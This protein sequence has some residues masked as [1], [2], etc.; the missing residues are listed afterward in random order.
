MTGAGAPAVG[1]RA[2]H[3]RPAVTL[4]PTVDPG[5][6]QLPTGASGSDPKRR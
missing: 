1:A 4:P 6:G 2:P 3:R 5:V